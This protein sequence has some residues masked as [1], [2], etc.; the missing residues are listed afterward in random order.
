MPYHWVRINSSPPQERRDE[1]KRTCEDY[2]A[3]LVGDEIYWDQT[4][5]AYALID[6]RREISDDEFETLLD[7]VGGTSWKGL[8][9][10]D[11]KNGGARPPKSRMRDEKS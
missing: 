8:V 2:G 5:Q 11:E 9:H 10:A 7:K 6:W 3:R 4:G 1:V